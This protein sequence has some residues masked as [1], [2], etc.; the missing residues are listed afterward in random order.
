[1]LDLYTVTSPVPAHLPK[2]R[3]PTPRP[4]EAHLKGALRSFS[5]TEITS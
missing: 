4:L 1:M 5:E 2:K 3:G